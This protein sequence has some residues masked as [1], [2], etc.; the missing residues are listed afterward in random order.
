MLQC[1]ACPNSIMLHLVRLHTHLAVS[2]LSNIAL[3]SPW[4]TTARS[5]PWAKAPM[6]ELPD[7]VTLTTP[8]FIDTSLWL[9]PLLPYIDSI[10][11]QNLACDLL[12]Q[13]FASS[14]SVYL[15]PLNPYIIAYAFRGKS[16]LSTSESRR[17]TL[18]L[19]SSMLWTAAQVSDAAFLSSQLD[20]RVR[21]YQNC[22]NSQL[23]C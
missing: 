17:C 12:E 9:R 11:P 4:V 7:W 20:A 14:T 13:Y 1:Q 2:M 8:M 22:S 19:I 3:C 18:T 21:A 23:A 5:H 10:V 6:V 16:F 15:R